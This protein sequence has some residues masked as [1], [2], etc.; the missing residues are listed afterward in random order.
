ML[1]FD[2]KALKPENVNI[3]SLFGSFQVHTKVVAVSNSP[4][5]PFGVSPFW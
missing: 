4:Y 2:F 3:L 1:A 5:T